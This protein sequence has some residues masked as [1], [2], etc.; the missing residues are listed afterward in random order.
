M[1]QSLLG[2]KVGDTVD[3][4]KKPMTVKDIKAYNA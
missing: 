2:A 4:V 1:A 3:V